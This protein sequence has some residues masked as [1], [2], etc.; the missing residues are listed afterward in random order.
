MKTILRFLFPLKP[1]NKEYSLFLLVFRI[2]F[3][4]LLMTHGIQKW[5]N[6]SELSQVFPDPLG[7]GSPVSLGLAI[8]GEVA[9]SIAFILGA[10]YRLAV[11]PML[12]TMMIAFFVIH[13]GDPFAAKEL[14]FVYMIVYVIL[15]MAGPGRYALDRVIAKAV[16]GKK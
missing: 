7:V 11:I 8:F 9:C 15:F 12:F 6:F 5:M 1:D 3:G 13:G 2:L 4:V 14:A 16:A 10:F